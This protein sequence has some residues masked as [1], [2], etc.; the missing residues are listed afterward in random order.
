M[1]Y[2]AT[3]ADFKRRIKEFPLDK[4]R[5]TGLKCPIEGASLFYIGHIDE[6]AT[7]KITYCSMRDGIFHIAYT[8]EK[9]EPYYRT[10]Y[11]SI[12]DTA[13]NKWLTTKFRFFVPDAAG[14]WT[15]FK[16]HFVWASSESTIYLP[17]DMP[18][19][20]VKKTLEILQDEE[21]IPPIAI[22]VATTTIG[23]NL[24][25]VQSMSAP[26]GNLFYFDYVFNKPTK[27]KNRKKRYGKDRNLLRRKSRIYLRKGGKRWK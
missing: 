7:G 4:L 16:T 24:L 27:F 21:G 5:D 3:A 8:R 15:E 18:E 2:P 10:S 25:S 1:Y 26:T 11:G 6:D 12:E 17:V 20:E 9:E 13:E 22:K 23:A 19:D 14:L